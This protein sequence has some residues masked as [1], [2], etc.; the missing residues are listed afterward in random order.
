[1]LVYFSESIIKFVYFPSRLCFFYLS[2]KWFVSDKHLHNIACGE[3]HFPVLPFLVLWFI[4][5][6]AQPRDSNISGSD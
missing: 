1:M 6:L 3:L 2:A 5:S 4:K